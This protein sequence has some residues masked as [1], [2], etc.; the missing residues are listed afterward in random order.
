ML[1]RLI[2]LAFF[3]QINLAQAAINLTG[4]Y[5]C[6]GEDFLNNSTFDEPTTLTKT[7]GTYLFE[8]Q[9][10]NVKFHGTA[11]LLDQTLSAIFWAPTIPAATPGIVA[12][13]VLP[14]G[15]LQG[16]WSLKNGQITGKEFC[17]K[18]P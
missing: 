18:L 15:D 11:I 6:T 4:K 1:L 14:N 13:K 17:K 10:K 8:W 7:G 9:N 5:R 12:Y 3:F 16:R 2:L